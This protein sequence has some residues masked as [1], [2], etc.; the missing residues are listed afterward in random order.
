M[1]STFISVFAGFLQIVFSGAQGVSVDPGQL[2]PPAS[3]SS[4]KDKCTVSGRVAS[5]QTG[6]P[7]KKATL[8]LTRRGESRSTNGSWE[9]TGYSGTSGPDGSFKFESVEPGEYSL[10]GE[11]P[12]YI[13]TEYGSKNGMFG[14]TRLKLQPAQQLTDLKLQ[15]VAQATVS[16]RV[17]DDDGD[18]VGGVS[19]EAVGRV[20]GQGGKPRF[21]PVGQGSTDDTGAFRIANLRPGKYYFA[22]QSNR[23]Q[24]MGMREAP[25]T[26]GKPDIQ[27]VRT[28]YPS[29]LDRASASAV[30]LK[31]GQDMPGVD[32]RMRSVETFHIRGKLADGLPESTGRPTFLMLMPQGDDSP[33]FMFGGGLV[34]KDRTFEFGGVAPGSYVISMMGNATGQQFARQAVEVG[35]AD[36][37]GVVITT[38]S[39][40][41]IRGAVELQGMLSGSSKDKSLESVQVM[42]TPDDDSVIM[43]NTSNAMT[44]ADGTFTLERVTPGKSRV[45][46]MNE[47]EGS[48]VKSI[49]FG[50][51][52]TLGK[53]LDLTQA[54]GG[55]IRVVL[56]S[57]A[58]EVSGTVQTKQESTSAGDSSALVPAT[59]ASIM[60]I[61][62]D[63]TL[64]G[65]SVHTSG[66]NQSGA[67]TAKGLAPGV[68]YA[69]AYQADEYR[70]F[71]DPAVLK[72]L[73]DKGTKVEVK[74]NDK[75]QIQ[76]TLLPADDLQA[77]LTAAGV[78]N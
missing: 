60:L 29:S 9:S 75:Q 2:K 69:L 44:K 12:G 28:F 66:T 64:N 34:A 31:S 53:T 59:S 6:E 57:G 5:M 7:L 26:P 36:V 72:Q 20:W 46:V 42:L 27:P 40:F 19:V 43:F 63:L 14:G 32:I 62:E 58:A 11:K 56:H 45:R 10:S 3:T 52:E 1:T 23:Q 55:E 48:Y 30:E 37:N 61:P 13:Q 21:F 33:S 65:G 49:R 38:Q 15:L 74:E 68:Y 70:N 25:A 51:Q 73:V 78:D 16:G 35:S 41:I 4:E 54:A 39:T 18:P 8:H 76:L 22:A 67:F 17:L 71:N 24:M 50:N 77:A 47:P